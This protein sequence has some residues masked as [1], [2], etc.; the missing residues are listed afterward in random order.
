MRDFT[1]DLKDVSRR[2]GEANVYLKIDAQRDRFRDSVSLKLKFLSL[3]FGM[4]KN[5]RKNST[6]NT[7]TPKVILTFLM[8]C[9]G[10]LRMPKYCMKW[11]AK[12]M[13]SRKKPK[14]MRVFKP[15]PK[16]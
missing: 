13:M 16:H 9:L 7:P 10:N 11:L 14:L 5:L 1:D 12:S 6:L 3:G 15:L 2:L 8:A 4:I